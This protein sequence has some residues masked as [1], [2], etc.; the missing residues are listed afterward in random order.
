MVMKKKK[1]GTSDR[2]GGTFAAI[3]HSGIADLRK[4]FRASN[5][6]LAKVLL[7]EIADVRHEL[8]EDIHAL[9]EKVGKIDTKVNQLD[10]KVGQLDVKVGQLDT[11]VN[12][13]DTKANTLSTQ[14]HLLRSELHQNHISFIENQTAMD[15]RVRVLEGAVGRGA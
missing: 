7:D 14:M 2:N 1:S 8:K 12:Q 10:T 5:K 6:K 15:K 4:E 9:D 3:V 13:L 11:K